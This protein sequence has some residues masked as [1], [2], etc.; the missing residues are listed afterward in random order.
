MAAR[1]AS[2][3]SNHPADASR[4]NRA[5]RYRRVI[6]H[7]NDSVAVDHD[8][9]TICWPNGVDLDPDVLYSIAT[10]TPLAFSDLETQAPAPVHT[11]SRTVPAM[12]E[13]C[14]FLGIII[15]MF[16][17]DHAPPHFHVEYSGDEALVAIDTLGVI[18]GRLPP[19]ALGLVVEWA[20]MHRDEL[21]ENWE[22]SRSGLPLKPVAPLE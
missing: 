11:A 10:G 9:G 5:T 15:R 7:R 16:Y 19:R 22:R 4:S 21:R 1:S 14:R 18:E 20:M 12:P 13:I 2:A 17:R 6:C 8:A 3:P